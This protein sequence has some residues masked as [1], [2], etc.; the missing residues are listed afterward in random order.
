MG[1]RFGPQRSR[2]SAKGD[3]GAGWQGIFFFIG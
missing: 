2:Q 3:A 1:T